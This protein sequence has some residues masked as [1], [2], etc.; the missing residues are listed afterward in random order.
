ML[1]SVMMM[2]G[3][4]WNVIDRHMRVDSGHFFG[5]GSCD[6]ICAVMAIGT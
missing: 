3:D 4:G 2:N 5:V 6:V 1:M